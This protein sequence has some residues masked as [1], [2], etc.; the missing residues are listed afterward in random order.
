MNWASWCK[1]VKISRMIR[2]IMLGFLVTLVAF[3]LTSVTFA[4]MRPLESATFPVGTYVIPMDEKQNALKP[5]NVTVF[6]FIW[7]I[8]ND[9]A[10]IYRIIEPPDVVLNT[11]AN[12]GGTVYSGGVILV[13]ASYGAIVTAQEGNFSTVVVDTL[14]EAFTSDKVLF[15]DKP[16]KI[17]VIRGF[18]E[19]GHTEI[20]LDWMKIP[21][22]IVDASEVQSDPTIILNYD[23]VVD[24]CEGFGGYVHINE[25]N[26]NMT[27]LVSNGGELIF[28]D[29]ALLDLASAFPGYVHVV[30][31]C[32]QSNW[33]GDANIYN[34][35][36]N[37]SAEYPSQ[38]SASF[39][40]TIKIH[41]MGGMRVVDRILN[42]TDV[43]VLMDT[44]T[45]NYDSPPPNAHYAIFGFYFP[46]GKGLVEG[47]T[48]HPFEQTENLTGDPNSY[49]CA[50]IF[51]GNKFVTA[52]PQPTLYSSDALG[53]EKNS[54]DT[55]E[56][57]YATVQATGQTVRL[58][59]VA[60]QTTWTTGDTLTDV[61]SDGYKELTLN[62]NGTQTIKLWDPP[63]AAGNYD[64]IEDVNC[65]GQYDQGIDAVDSVT[66]IGFTVVP[67]LSFGTTTIILISTTT[68]LIGF[69]KL[70]RSKQKFLPK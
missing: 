46:Y 4:E 29:K 27:A 70:K 9:G 23:L 51:Y 2:K 11:T 39:P 54:F 55:A 3:S 62:A 67:E 50:A 37:F 35:P 28:T 41:E 16:T 45:F 44:S 19:F 22:T 63:L 69:R 17:L 33:T 5:E 58:Y 24:D 42:T 1:K 10:D 40:S 34:P 31:G 25:L 18:E 68:A 53:N 43:R 6:G 8:L 14:T 66:L 13:N 26:T 12:P 59:V 48:Y 15:V 30:P 65:N 56:T 38:Y 49:V 61:S 47:F 64:I 57:V 20:T 36:I 60:D 52:V 32:S 21:Y 7:A